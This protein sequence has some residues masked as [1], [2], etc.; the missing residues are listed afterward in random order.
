MGANTGDLGGPDA[1]ISARGVSKRFLI[2]HQRAT[3][4][5]DRLVKTKRITHE[6]FWAL[7]YVD[8]QIGAGQTVGLIGANG[9]GKSTLLKLLAGI[10][11]PTRGKVAVRGRIASL[12]ELGA[13]FNG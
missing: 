8:L 4:L 11:E 9:S 10:L 13:G 6:D 2:Y 3:S 12:L 1:V 7:R 5:K